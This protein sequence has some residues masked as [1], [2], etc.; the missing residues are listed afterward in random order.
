MNRRDHV[1]EAQNKHLA[2][3]SSCTSTSP[4]NPHQKKCDESVH[5]APHF[6]ASSAKWSINLVITRRVGLSRKIE[7]SRKNAVALPKHMQLATHSEDIPFWP[8][9]T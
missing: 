1:M 8:R 7:A 3:V 6:L 2:F 4:W 5:S 9:T